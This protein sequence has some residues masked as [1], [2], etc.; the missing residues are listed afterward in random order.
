MA[1]LR[2]RDVNGRDTDP[3][4]WLGMWAQQYPEGDYSGYE[5]LMSKH[6]RF[7]A[8][9]IERVGRWKDAAHTA[10][11]WKPNTAS[12]AYSV[13]MQAAAEL[14]TC[15]S[16]AQAIAEF[17][18]NWSERS[19]V[20]Q[21]RTKAVPK[22]FGL[23]RASTL[24]HFLSGGQ[25]PIFD[26]RIRRALVRVLGTTVPNNIDWY[27]QSYCPVVAQIAIE[28]GTS[29]LRMVDKALFSYGGKNMPWEPRKLD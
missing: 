6:D 24:L 7:T 19:Y 29:D 9:D 28:C 12:V 16:D 22:R 11:K 21:F 13:W 20:D 23:S 26:S 8:D 4:S 2:F 1:K 3:N 14:P 18:T 27:I 5:Q 25:F 15:P 17:L 10:A